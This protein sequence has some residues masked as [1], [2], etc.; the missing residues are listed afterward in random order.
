[1]ALGSQVKKNRFQIYLALFRQF[2]RSV[3]SLAWMSLVMGKWWWQFLFRFELDTAS[4]KLEC[5]SHL[6]ELRENHNAV[7]SICVHPM[8]G[9]GIVK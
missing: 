7:A 3:N 9:C 8:G 6:K 4:E 5:I 2:D 1:M